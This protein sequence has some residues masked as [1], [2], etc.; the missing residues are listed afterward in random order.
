MVS[1][2]E[3][4]KADLLTIPQRIASADPP[5]SQ[6]HTIYAQTEKLFHACI[7]TSNNENA[8]LIRSV[9]AEGRQQL[10]EL[11]AASEVLQTLVDRLIS[12]M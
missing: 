8:Q 1:K 11:L 7:G 10:V 2:L 9:L 5:I 3:E 12:T 4:L 6:A